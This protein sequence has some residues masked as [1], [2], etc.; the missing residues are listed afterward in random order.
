MK[1]NDFNTLKSL[2]MCSVTKFYCFS[3]YWFY[4]YHFTVLFTDFHQI[5]ELNKNW[6]KTEKQGKDVILEEKIYFY[7]ILRYLSGAPIA[8]KFLFFLMGFFVYF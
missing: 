2:E 6:T 1:Q 4:T 8:E 3:F 5:S 7:S